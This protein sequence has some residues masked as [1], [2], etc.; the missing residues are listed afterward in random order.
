MRASGYLL[1]TCGQL[2]VIMLTRYF[3]Q[4]IIRFSDGAVNAA[5]ATSTANV[6]LFSAAAV[7][8]VFFGFRIFD[9]VIDPFLGM[10]SDA[11]ARRGRARRSLLWFAFPL[12][13]IGLG[14]VFSPSLEMAPA[15]RWTLL[16]VGMVLFFFGYSFY[17]IPFRS[18]IDDYS[19]GDAV[20]RTRISNAQGLGLLL[21]TGVGFV[22]SPLVVSRWGFRGGAIA[23]ALLSAMLMVL[24][25]FAAPKGPPAP[26]EPDDSNPG[27]KAIAAA[28]RDRSFRAVVVLFAGAQMSFTVMTASAPYIA[29]KLLGGTLKDV[30]LLLGPFLL[31]A[32]LS[33]SFV[34][35]LAARLGW[36]KAMLL[37]TVVLGVVYSG[38]GLLGHA[39]VGSP[40]TTAMLVFAGAGPAAAVILGLEAEAIIR[41][42][43]AGG[44]GRTGVY[45]GTF[46]FVVQAMNGLAVYLMGMLAEQARSS[47]AMVRLMPVLAGGLCLTGVVLY[48]TLRRRSGA[49]AANVA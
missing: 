11:W 1:Y 40:M 42:A 48:L 3:F 34:P 8:A 19:G 4:W 14:F 36:E 46:N 17:S 10:F 13:P 32:I 44:P 41:S 35:R 16:V 49:P 22:L 47:V 28:F 9:A 37:A 20:V 33:F 7:G 15:L 12:A 45:F 43:A 29:E 26:A 39:V 24:P 25:Y 18:L 23:F 38:A 21:A 6:A 2:G 5:P 30:A 31:T 27:F